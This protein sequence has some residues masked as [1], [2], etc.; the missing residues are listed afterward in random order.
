[1]I[2]DSDKFSRCL[3]GLMSFGRLCVVYSKPSGVETKEGM[4][5]RM[6]FLLIILKFLRT[7]KLMGLQPFNCGSRLVPYVLGSNVALRWRLTDLPS[8]S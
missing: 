7:L 2:G 5:F 3:Y 6:V 1:M 4:G 8:S